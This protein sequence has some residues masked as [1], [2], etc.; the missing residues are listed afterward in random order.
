MTICSKCNKEKKTDFRKHRTVCR[1][2]DNLLAREKRKKTKNWQRLTNRLKYY[3]KNVIKFV[4]NLDIIGKL[5]YHVKEN[6]VEN[7]GKIQQK[8]KNGLKIIEKE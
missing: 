3:A 1:V 4:Q 7:I 6:M 2:C 5:V 8:Q